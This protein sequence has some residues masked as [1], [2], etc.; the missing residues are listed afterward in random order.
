MTAEQKALIE[1]AEKQAASLRNTAQTW[2]QDGLNT[3]ALSCEQDAELFIA[4][5]VE[6]RRAARALASTEETA[7]SYLATTMRLEREQDAL[8]ERLANCEAATRG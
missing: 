3:W 6:L 8:R 2:R 1:R 4:L 5:A 7:K